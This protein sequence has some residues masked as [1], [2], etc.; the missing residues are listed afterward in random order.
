[1]RKEPPVKVKVSVEEDKA[2]EQTRWMYKNLNL[3]ADQYEKVNEINLTYAFKIDSVEK[4]KLNNLKKDARNKLK[5]A[6]EARLR[7]VLTPEQYNLFLKHKNIEQKQTKS[8]FSGPYTE[9][10]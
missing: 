9:H 7:E 10:N 3:A 4:L 5:L 2:R 8:P 1:M 6:K